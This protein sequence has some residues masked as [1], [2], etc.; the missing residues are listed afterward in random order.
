MFFPVSVLAFCLLAMPAPAQVSVDVTPAPP[1]STL[2]RISSNFL[3][4]STPDPAEEECGL[5]PKCEV[6]ELGPSDLRKVKDDFAAFRIE[7]CREL[8]VAEGKVADAEHGYPCDGMDGKVRSSGA[9]KL[10]CMCWDAYALSQFVKVKE[11]K[12]YF[13][14]A[15]QTCKYW[16]G[17]GDRCGRA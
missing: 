2:A 15:C 8:A 10:G 9:K 13:K 17:A 12:Q 11:T 14:Q 5:D 16:V 1:S 7:A 4:P 3:P 6:V